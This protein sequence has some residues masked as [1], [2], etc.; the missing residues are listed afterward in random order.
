MDGRCIN[1]EATVKFDGRTSRLHV[2][3]QEP[4]TLD[5]RR[6]R[7]AIAGNQASFLEGNQR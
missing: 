5:M 4:N 3:A 2:F 7:S 1:P 6:G